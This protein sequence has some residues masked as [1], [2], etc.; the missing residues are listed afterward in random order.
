M[1]KLEI[2]ELPIGEV[3]EYENNPRENE[4]AAAKVA[5]S[6]IEFGF[7]NP[8]A[9]DRNN[10]IIAGHARLKAAR[11]LGHETVPCIVHDVDGDTARIARI[12]ENRT[13]DFSTWDLGKLITGLKGIN[14]ATKNAFFAP[15]GKDKHYYTE[16]K[17][18]AFGKIEAAISPEDEE[19]FAAHFAAYVERHG[20]HLGFV[21]Y[22]LGGVVDE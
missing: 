15:A 5:Q 3:I 16:N 20:S 9:V 4:E 7:L 22:M 8:I 2:I 10:V 21:G 18:L 14:N 6:I 17:V 1:P 12:A 11:R 19:L 13:R